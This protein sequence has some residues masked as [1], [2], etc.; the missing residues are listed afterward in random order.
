MVTSENCLFLVDQLPSLRMAHPGMVVP[1][2]SLHPPSSNGMEKS[3]VRADFAKCLA[4]S[5]NMSSSRLLFT[6]STVLRASSSTMNTRASL[7]FDD[8]VSRHELQVFPKNI[9]SDSM[10]TRQPS[11]HSIRST[12]TFF[13]LSNLSPSVACL[14]RLVRS[15]AKVSQRFARWLLYRWML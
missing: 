5:V 11:F 13:S 2:L 7:P 4:S 1:S 12:T 8:E 15:M 14:S 3:G 9:H 10:C 6:P